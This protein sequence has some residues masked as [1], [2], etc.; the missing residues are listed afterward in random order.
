MFLLYTTCDGG[1]YNFKRIERMAID[2]IRGFSTDQHT[3]TN[4]KEKDHPELWFADSK[5]YLSSNWLVHM[6]SLRN[7]LLKWNRMRLVITLWDTRNSELFPLDYI[8]NS[9]ISKDLHEGV[10]GLSTVKQIYTLSMCSISKEKST[11][12]AKNSKWISTVYIIYL[13]KP[14]F[15]KSEILH[16]RAA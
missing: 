8:R 16:S 2:F 1:D 14:N 12:I 3:M 5:Q 13:F 9:S 7:G 6:N 15:H 10:W 4:W 11:I